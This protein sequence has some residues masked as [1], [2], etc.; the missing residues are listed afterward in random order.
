MTE[1]T[2]PT[3]FWRQQCRRAYH[4]RRLPQVPR[5]DGDTIDPI[6]ELLPWTEDFVDITGRESLT[7]RFRT[8]ARVGWDEHCLYVL[9]ELEEPHVWATITED[10]EVMF[11]DNNFEVFIDPDRDG[12][13]Y[14]EC[15]INANAAIWELNLPKPYADG[16]VANLGCN[17]DGLIR[18]VRIN[19]TLNDPRDTDRGWTV[20][21][22]IPWA[23]L[24]PYHVDG[25]CPPV[26]GDR[27]RLNFSRVEWQHEIVDGQ[28]VRIPPHGTPLAESL[29]PEE[30]QHPE[31]NWVWSPQGVV[32]MHK[33]ER[34]GEL[35]F[36]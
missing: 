17:I 20:E 1:R 25:L 4:C 9:G 23:G 30:Q 16:G 31:D 11:M 13:G 8:R 12:L 14:Y 28:Y 10:N 24:A 32:N 19:G 27:W 6:W 36:E 21:L 18:R 2:D 26:P 7:P 15:E 22:A 5:L 33:P 34:W 35:I 29:N 3:D